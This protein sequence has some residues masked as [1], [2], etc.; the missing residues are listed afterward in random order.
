VEIEAFFTYEKK[1]ESEYFSTTY[2]RKRCGKT[3][4]FIISGQVVRVGILIFDL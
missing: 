1:V 3:R 4:F 2:Y